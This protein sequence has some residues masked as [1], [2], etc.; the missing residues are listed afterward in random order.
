MTC[1]DWRVGTERGPTRKGPASD[2]TTSG[3]SH[4][5]HRRTDVTIEISTTD[6]RDGKALALFARCA[7]WQTG[8][9]KAGRSFFAIPG[10]E[11]GLVHMADQRDCSCPDRQSS[12]NVCKHMRAVRLWMAA[13]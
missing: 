7:E 2:I 12:R 13:F 5:S 8:H 4:T 3:T 1:Y 10:S 9:T 6:K 11:P